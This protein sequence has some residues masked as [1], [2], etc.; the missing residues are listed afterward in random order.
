MV[1]WCVLCIA[2]QWGAGKSDDPSLSWGLTFSDGK[3]VSDSKQEDTHSIE[4]TNWGKTE[5]HL[6]SVRNE[7]SQMI[8]KNFSRLGD[9]SHKFER[10]NDLPK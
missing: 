5:N 10:L 4:W 1:G 9:F 7:W 3:Q 6:S 2:L 8:D